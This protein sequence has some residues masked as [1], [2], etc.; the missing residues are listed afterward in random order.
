MKLIKMIKDKI[1]KMASNYA[2]RAIVHQHDIDT[3]EMI[4][5]G[6]H[7]FVVTSTPTNT[8]LLNVYIATFV[9]KGLPLLFSDF[10]IITEDTNKLLDVSTSDL[11]ALWLKQYCLDEPITELINCW[12]KSTMSIQT[13]TG[14]YALRV[15][16]KLM[17]YDKAHGTSLLEEV[18]VKSFQTVISKMSHGDEPIELINRDYSNQD[19]FDII[20][21]SMLDEDHKPANDS[22]LLVKHFTEFINLFTLPLIIIGLLSMVKSS[23]TIYHIVTGEA[24]G[25]VSFATVGIAMILFGSC[26]FITNNIF[27]YT[28]RIEDTKIPTPL[29]IKMN[30]TLTYVYNMVQRHFKL[31]FEKEDDN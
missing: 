2:V 24:S 17:A 25:L 4:I 5:N 23:I 16:D 1:I 3:N 26:Y 9:S 31:C 19:M 14:L 11:D 6:E 18:A 21:H 13:A 22:S 15:N 28:E 8:H 20:K 10:K 27:T 29:K 30:Q 12:M 7:R